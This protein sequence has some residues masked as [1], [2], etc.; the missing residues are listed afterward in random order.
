MTDNMP[1]PVRPQ[2]LIDEAHGMGIQVLLDIVHS[3]ISSNVND[4]LAGDAAEGIGFGLMAYIFHPYYTTTS[5]AF[6]AL[7]RSLLG[8]PLHHLQALTSGRARTATTS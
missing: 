7:S 3:H 8:L 6:T 2:A 5:L 4:G 1:V